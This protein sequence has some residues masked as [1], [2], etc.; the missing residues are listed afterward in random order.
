MEE[1]GVVRTVCTARG[2]F[3]L[4]VTVY[5]IHIELRLCKRSNVER[6]RTVC[7]RPTKPTRIRLLWDQE[8]WKD[9]GRT[10]LTVV[11]KILLGGILA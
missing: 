9:H 10:P 1:G 3:G 6:T 8:E 11:R 4:P 7:V 5:V 2:A